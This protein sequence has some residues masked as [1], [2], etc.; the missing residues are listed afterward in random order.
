MVFDLATWHA[1]GK[2]HAQTKLTLVGLT[3][4]CID[5]GKDLQLFSSKTCQHWVTTEL[6]QEAAAC[7]LHKARM[8]TAGGAL[9]CKFKLFSMMTY[10]YHS[11]ADYP[12]AIRGFGSSDNFN[13]Q[14]VSLWLCCTIDV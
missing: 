11:L 5:V 6:P 1:L 7:G 3:T 12:S 8:R 2:L 4:T 13:T 10:K 9:P 14:T